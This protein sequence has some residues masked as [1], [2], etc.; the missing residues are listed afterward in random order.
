MKLHQR[1]DFAWEMR[2]ESGAL[3]AVISWDSALSL[4]YVSLGDAEAEAFCSFSDACVHAER[5][6]P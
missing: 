1:E 4:Y 5:G 2:E 6:G 3:R